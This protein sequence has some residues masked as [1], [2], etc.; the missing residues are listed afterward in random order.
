MR[1]SEYNLCNLKENK[2]R[3]VQWKTSVKIGWGARFFAVVFGS[4]SPRI[5]SKHMFGGVLH[6][7]VKCS[8]NVMKQQAQIPRLSFIITFF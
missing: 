6:N 7:A 8:E 1:F 3:T 2:S 4:Y 5:C